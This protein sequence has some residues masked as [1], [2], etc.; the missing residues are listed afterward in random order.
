MT[1]HRWRVMQTE[2]NAELKSHKPL[3]RED[4]MTHLPKHR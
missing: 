1:D 3:R 2:P 4:L